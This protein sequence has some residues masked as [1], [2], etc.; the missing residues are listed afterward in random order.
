MVDHF[1]FLNQ[2]A[3]HVFDRFAAVG[4]HQMKESEKVFF[5]IWS[6]HGEIDNG[7]FDQFYFNSS[8]DFSAHT[9]AAL[10]AIG[11]GSLADIISRANALFPEG[12]PEDDTTRQM[13]LDAMTEE[14][15]I[16]LEEL[17]DQFSREAETIDDLLYSFTTANLHPN[18]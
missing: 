9:P 18:E 10:R 4:F 15:Q 5:L 2:V 16:L 8:G 14:K 11:A 3:D 6:A 12:P 7:G 1:E 17:G 13:Q